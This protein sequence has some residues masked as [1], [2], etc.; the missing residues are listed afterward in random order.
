MYVAFL[1]EIIV[2][3][4]SLLILGLV[5]ARGINPSEALWGRLRQYKQTQLRIIF[6]FVR[7]QH[8]WPTK[9]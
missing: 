5:R 3:I 6:Q 1:L 9:H 7:E 4:G 8:F 2:P